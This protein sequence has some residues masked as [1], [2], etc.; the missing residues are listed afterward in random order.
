MNGTALHRTGYSTIAIS[1]DKLNRTWEMLNFFT[2]RRSVRLFEL[3]SRIGTL[4]FACKA[5]VP[6]RTLFRGSLI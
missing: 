2:E 6:G 1:Q 4:Q 5:V 3:Q